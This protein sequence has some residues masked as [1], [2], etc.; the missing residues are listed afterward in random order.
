M[1]TVVTEPTWQAILPDGWESQRD[2]NCVT[3]YHPDG[4][5]ALQISAA[6]KYFLVTDEDLRDFA[7]EHLQAGAKIRELTCGEFAGF[8]LAFGVDDAYWRHWYL[9]RDNQMLFVTYNCPRDDRGTEDEPV[10]QILASLRHR[11]SGD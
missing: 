10:S 4:V 8:T 3:L 7:S 9:R 6:F 11:R 5:G 1:T 2:D